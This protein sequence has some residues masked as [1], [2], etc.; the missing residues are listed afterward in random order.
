MEDIAKFPGSANFLDERFTVRSYESGVS[1]EV[2]LATLCNYMQESAGL[3]ADQLGW[4]IHKL[5]EE[6]LT[7]MLSRL[8][9]KVSRYVP[10]GTELTLRTWPSGMKGK[11]LATRC[12][13]AADR[14]GEEVFQAHSEWLYVDMKSQRIVKLPDDFAKLVPEGTPSVAFNDLG[15]KSVKLAEPTAGVEIRVRRSDLDFND[16]VNNVHYVEWMLE[17]LP[18]RGGPAEIDVVFRSAAKAGDVLLSEC[19]CE[20]DRSLHQIR[21]VSDG[22]VLA[23]AAMVWRG[24]VSE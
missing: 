6:G 14:S 5:Q 24:G 18:E 20:A 4:G 11:L 12:F 9:V 17:S 3:S 10:W 23:T 7:W 8:Y 22:A 15:G 16:H 13:Q 1:N 21:R 19:L 2:S